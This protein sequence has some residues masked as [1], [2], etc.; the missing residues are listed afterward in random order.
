MKIITLTTDFGLS[1][2]FVGT[3]KGVILSLQPRAT[4]V[5][6]THAL[7]AGDVRAGAFALASGYRYFP[8]GTVHLAVV[9]PGVGSAR[10]ALAVRT[11]DYWFV[12][13]DNGLLSW[14]LAGET[15]RAI[16]RLENERYFLQPVSRTFHGR[17]VFAPVAAWI[18]R[19]TPLDRLGPAQR[20]WV[21]LPWP[22]PR[23]LPGQIRGEVIWVDH[24][25]NAITNIHG[26]LLA[27]CAEAAW[28]VQVRT[29]ALGRLRG[30]YA[31]ARSGEPLALLSSSGFL[32]IAVRGGSAARELRLQAGVEVQVVQG[33][34]SK[35]IRRPRSRRR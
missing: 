31:E 23:T 11:R 19:G 24:F 9:D 22:Q 1:D 14:A 17:D 27:A 3:M 10:G 30:C 26:Q 15:I 16:H 7:P 21:R 12:G 29:R 13:P 35:E 34:S 4:L 5:D 8:R 2:W 18:S 25:G 6:L 32:E 28:E 20:D 33:S